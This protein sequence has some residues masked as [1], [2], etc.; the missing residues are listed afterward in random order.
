MAHYQLCIIII[1]II[2]WPYANQWEHEGSKFDDL[3]LT[4][5]A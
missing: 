2:E 4:R 1:I 5:S 3:V